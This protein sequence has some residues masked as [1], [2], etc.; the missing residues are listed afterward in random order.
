MRD[1]IDFAPVAVIPH[2]A[3]Y[4]MNPKEHEELQRQVRELLEKGSIRE[5]IGSC[6][7][8]VL[9]VPK[10]DGPWRMNRTWDLTPFSVTLAS[11]FTTRPPLG[12]SY[13]L[14]SKLAL[15][16][17]VPTLEVVAYGVVAWTRKKKGANRDQH[18]R[19]QR[20]RSGGLDPK[21]GCQPCLLLLQASFLSEF[22]TWTYEPIR[23]WIN[24]NA[25]KIDLPGTYNVS[26]TFNVADLSLYVTDSED[27]E[28]E[29]MTSS[30]I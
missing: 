23:A 12:G 22:Y 20:A 3:A 7:V 21:R 24:D 19:D 16:F 4:R 14:V 5:S 17:E 25:Y 1:I 8:P 11:P 26:A 15:P 6:A 30:K 9:L 10:K 27:D 29:E 18:S 2:K 28:D 13:Q